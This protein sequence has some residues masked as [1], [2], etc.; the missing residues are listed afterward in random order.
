MR[1]ELIEDK[2]GLPALMIDGGHLGRSDI[3]GI[4]NIGNQR[5]NLAAIPPALDL[6]I[7]GT[8]TNS[9]Q[10]SDLHQPPAQPVQI[11]LFA[12]GSAVN[13]L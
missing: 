3:A 12:S 9:R 1:L 7:D 5:Y 2:L 10:V 6:V 11:S 8:H 4:G 13:D